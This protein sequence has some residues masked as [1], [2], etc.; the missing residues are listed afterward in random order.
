MPNFDDKVK[1]IEQIAF[2]FFLDKGYDATTVRMICQKAG[3][4]SPTLYYYFGSKKGL[5]FSIVISLLKQYG[6]IL[7]ERVIG[8]HLTAK[9]K[10]YNFYEHSINF[11]I[12]HFKETKFYLR[13]ALFAPNDL[14]D[15]I[16][17]YMKETFDRRIELYQ[18]C[19]EA[20]IKQGEIQC[21]VQTGVS[22]LLNLI[23]SATYN[24]VFSNWRPSTKELQE[25]LDIF[26]TYQLRG[27]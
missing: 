20:C 9:E 14:Q 26:Y 19:I 22:K 17:V 24:V 5:F 25:N 7:R 3:I 1:I 27:K 16:Q 11:T 8:E 23:D 13:F 12:Q 4:E 6:L 2:D 18:E 21:D 15:D 10:L